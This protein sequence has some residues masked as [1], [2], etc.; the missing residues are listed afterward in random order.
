MYVIHTM[1][2]TWHNDKAKN[3]EAKHGITFEETIGCFFDPAQVA[4]YDPDHSDY[5]DR[6]IVIGHSKRGRLLLVIYTV[7]GEVIRLISARLATKH[8][9]K[10]YAKRV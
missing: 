7:R 3:N 2:F 4:F 8:E 6:E 5:E 10:S 9:A 1:E